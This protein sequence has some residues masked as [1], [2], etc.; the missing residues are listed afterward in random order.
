MLSASLVEGWGLTLTEAAGCGTPAV[1]TDIR[2]HRS[3]VIDG[4]TGVLAPRNASVPRSRDVL[5]DAGLRHRLAAAAQERAS[6]LTWEAS[7]TGVLRVLRDEILRHRQR[8][9]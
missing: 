1:A 8:R 5:T 2:G 7:A 9:R 4:V 6:T 3:S